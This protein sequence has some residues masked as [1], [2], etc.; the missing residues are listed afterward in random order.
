[1]WNGDHE[2]SDFDVIVLGSGLAG[3]ITATI[4]SK[5][6]HRVALI[7]K[8]EHP[9]LAIGESLIPTSAMWFW[10]LG[11]KYGIPELTTLAHIDS[12]SRNIAPTSG[13]KRGFGYVYHREGQ[14]L[15]DPREASL[16]IGAL[17]P[18]FKESQFYR[19]DIDH[20]MVQA[21]QRYGVD[22]RDR[23]VVEDVRIDDDAVTVA[24]ADGPPIT[25]RFIIDATGRHSVLADKFG[26]REEPTRLRHSSRTI[27]SHMRGVRPFE[28][29]APEATTKRRSASWSHGTLHHVF[30]GG[31]FW[32]IPFDNH[33]SSESDLVSV[34]VTV[35][36]DRHPKLDG[37]KPE[38]EFW[39]FVRRFPVIERH[40]GAAVPARDFVGTDRLQYSSTA[41]VG[42]RFLLLQHA[43]GFIDPLFSRGIWRSLETVDAVCRSLHDALA[44]DDLGAERFKPIEVM[45]AAMLDDN[46]Q[47]V[48]NAYRSMSSYDTWTAWLRVWFAEEVMT[49]LPVLSATFGHTATGDLSAFDRLDGDPRP[50][51]AYSFSAGLQELV[52]RTEAE[53]DRHDRGEITAAEL[54]AGT[55]DRL[56]G[57]DFLPPNLI[58]WSSTSDFSLDLTPRLLAK[59]Q[60]WGR[61]KAPKDLQAE[62]FDFSIRALAGLQVRDTIRPGSIRRDEFGNIISQVPA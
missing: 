24:I 48:H 6:G 21:S 52:D 38:K 2:P 31:W 7:E 43:Y 26:L 23:T 5:L 17:Q 27:F 39:S 4:L 61:T 33:K 50:G 13:L 40:L 16:F 51:T 25:G 62:A 15:V 9:R 44:E 55:V 3:S 8:G 22:Y 28:E 47:M 54:L 1:M 56:A 59:L 58:D 19:Q 12:I 42:D 46:D 36:T 35:G 60:W 10:I 53:L 18:M 57:A 20:H 37:I 49:T 32:I 45:Q 30:D 14:E 34:G 11:Q 41:A 29:V